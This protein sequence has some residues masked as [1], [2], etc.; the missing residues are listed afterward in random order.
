[1]EPTECFKTS[2][3]NIQTPGNTQKKIPKIWN[4]FMFCRFRYPVKLTVFTRFCKAYRSL[5]T[6]VRWNGLLNRFLTL[7]RQA[8]GY[9]LMFVWRERT[10]LIR[11][12]AE[13][14]CSYFK[15]H[16]VFH[17]LTQNCLQTGITVKKISIFVGQTDNNEPRLTSQRRCLWH[18][19][20]STLMD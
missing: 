1:M 13:N 8:T 9:T 12:R 10:W 14:S 2:A 20:T 5:I 4:F 7:Y 11:I 18:N 17:R 6:T 15:I 3:F 19:V 16:S